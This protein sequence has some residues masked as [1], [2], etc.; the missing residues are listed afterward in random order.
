[1]I[2]LINFILLYTAFLIG[3]AAYIW[4]EPPI[5]IITGENVNVYAPDQFDPETTKDL[6]IVRIETLEDYYG[7]I[8]KIDKIEFP[9]IL[10]NF[11]EQGELYYSLLSEKLFRS[12]VP[13]NSI[14]VSEFLK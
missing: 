10:T 1:M 14:S 5:A 13:V 6:R 2:P 12:N 3:I 8:V 4:F 9:A 7:L 11:K